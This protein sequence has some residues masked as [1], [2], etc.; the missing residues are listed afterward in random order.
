MINGNVRTLDGGLP[1][2]E[3]V[4]VRDGRIVH[5]GTNED[6]RS[7]AGDAPVF[8]AAGRTVVPGFVDGHAHLEMTCLALTRS[9]SCTVPPFE[10]L[11]MI[12]DELGNVAERTPPGEWIVGRSSFGLQLRVPEERLFTRHDLDAVSRQH[13]IVVY[14]SIHVGMLNTLALQELGLW[15][16]DRE[17]DMGIIVHR[18]AD[19][20]PT[21][22]VTEMWDMLPPF[23]ADEVEDALRQKAKELFVANGVTTIHNLPF[24]RHDLLAVQNLQEAGELP[25]RL[26]Y[27]VHAGRHME[28]AELNALGIKPGFGDELLAYGG[29]KA[30]VDGCCHDGYGNR[31]WDAKWTRAELFD[32][33][34]EV[35]GAGH[36]LWMHINSQFSIDMALDAYEHALNE[37]PRPHRHRLEHS[38]D[39]IDC[40]PFIE[41]FKRLGI[42]VVTTP[43]FIYSQGDTMGNRYPRP[44]QLRSLVE[45]GIE[46]IGSSDSTGTVPDGIT[47]MFNIAC[48]VTRRTQKGNIYLPEEA[49]S[50]EDAFRMFTIW[51]ARWA[52]EDHL[53]GTISPGKLAD[54]AVLSSDPFT[55]EPEAIFDISVDATILGGE[56]VHQR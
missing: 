21:G 34:S 20:T 29:V 44:F 40:Q 27:F 9:L 10:S 28:L 39:F 22:V 24:S 46:V 1:S 30:F 31:L 32:F 8:D 19:G 6:V 14:S 48:A 13:P 23:E 4:F 45:S 25:L 16:S 41:R 54:F 42:G 50:V 12:A 17:P 49:V 18:D 43:Q 37:Q 38:G 33:V 36:Q 15:G 53:K 11:A 52:F 51:P 7:I 3:A 26:R 2:A 5:V 47:P 35:H 56:I 55:A